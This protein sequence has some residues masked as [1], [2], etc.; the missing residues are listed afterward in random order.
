MNRAA[1]AAYE[2]IKLA[3]IG[4]YSLVPFEEYNSNFGRNDGTY[5]W[6]SETIFEPVSPE[7][8]SG[9]QTA[10]HGRL[11]T[12]ARFG[13]N[14]I[15]ETPT[16]NLVDEF[17][18]ANGL[19]IDDPASGY[20]PMDPWSNRDPRFRNGILVDR[21]QW[22]FKDPDKRQIEFF[23]GGQDDNGN[24]RSPYL[25]KKYW[26]KGV[27]TYDRNWDQFVYVNPHIRLAEIYLIYAEAVNEVS[28][29]NGTA[30]G[31]GLTP[32]QAVNIVRN[33]AG[34]PNVNPKFTGNKEAFRMRIWNERSVELFFEGN[35]WFDIRRWHVAHLDEYKMLYRLD[36]DKDYSYFN[37][38]HFTTRVF[39]EKHYW[40]P[41]Y[42]YQTQIYS[43]F[44]QNPG[45]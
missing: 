31:A 39:D 16:Q 22:T 38:T 6:T 20:D 34:M 27:N 44:S 45:W 12:P 2:V 24:H 1:S 7:R 43:G 13:G 33:R 35:R 19:P 4:V 36:F 15:C 8:G 17:E 18:M 5:P 21:D 25:C 10:R 30:S 42:T 32:V 9:Q 26:P 37:K 23:K 41:I 28:G 40:L 29:P 14:G 11:L 3:D